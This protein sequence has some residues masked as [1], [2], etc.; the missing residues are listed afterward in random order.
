MTTFN[1]SLAVHVANA[2]PG[3]TEAKHS[4]RVRTVRN[5]IDAVLCLAFVVIAFA[6]WGWWLTEP[7]R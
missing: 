7:G 3:G 6:V 2:T 4:R 5:V 1:K